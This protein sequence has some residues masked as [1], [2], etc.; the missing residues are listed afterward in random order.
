VGEALGLRTI[1]MN[2]SHVVLPLVIGAFGTVL[3]AAPAFWLMATALVGGGW[4]AHRW[5]RN[6]H[7]KR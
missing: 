6:G 1:V 5:T 7:G 3:G 4:S 2:S